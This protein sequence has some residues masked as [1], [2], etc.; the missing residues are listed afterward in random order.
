MVV[1]MKLIQNLNLQ[2]VV[3]PYTDLHAA[4]NLWLSLVLT[5]FLS[6]F[7]FNAQLDFLHVKPCYTGQI[8]ERMEGSRISDNHHGVLERNTI[9][10]LRLIKEK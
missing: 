6:L 4:Y 5:I 10:N 8:P 1:T 9:F 3:R 7:S 2:T